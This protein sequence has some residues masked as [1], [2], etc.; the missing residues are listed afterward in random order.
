MMDREPLPGLAEDRTRLVE[1]LASGPD[2]TGAH[3][4]PAQFSQHAR[5]RLGRRRLGQRPAQVRD[6]RD[7]GPR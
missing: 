2:G 4:G 5:A 1:V 6:G 3:L 7:G